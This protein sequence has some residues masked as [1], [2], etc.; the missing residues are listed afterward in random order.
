MGKKKNRIKRKEKREKFIS[1][2]FE[3]L[4]EYLNKNEIE[5]FEMEDTEEEIVCIKWCEIGDNFYD[6]GEEP[7]TRI[8]FNKGLEFLKDDPKVIL[9]ECSECCACAGW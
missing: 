3:E 2:N 1:M 4:K 6:Y 9:I 8:K 7:P 5:F